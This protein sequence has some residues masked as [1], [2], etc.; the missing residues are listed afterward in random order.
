[1]YLS[2]SLSIDTIVN[3]T[4]ASTNSVHTCLLRATH[5]GSFYGAKDKARSRENPCRI[6]VA[7]VFVQEVFLWKVEVSANAISDVIL[8]CESGT[9]Q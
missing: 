3:K 1:M 4:V 8:E 7:A 5:S 2:R 9:N 6:A